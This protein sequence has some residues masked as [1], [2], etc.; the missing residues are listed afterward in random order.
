MGDAR[1]PGLPGKL[2]AMVRHATVSSFSPEQED[3]GAFSNLKSELAS[4]FPLVHERIPHE[5]VGDRGLLYS[6]KGRDP[7]LAPAML[8]AHF[9]VVPAADADLW[10]HGPFSGDI[11]EGCLW[12]RGTQDIKVCMATILEAAENLLARGFEPLRT[13]YFAF[14]GDEETG[15]SRGARRIAALLEERG[16]RASF[17][18]DEGGPVSVGLVSFVAEPL[19]L[20]GV[21]EKGYMDV[22]LEASGKG[23][24]ASMPPRRTAAGD[25]ARAV[26][27]MEAK[28]FPA[29]LARTVRGFLEAL[30]PLTRR[31]YRFLF[32]HLGLSG[33]LVMKAFA[34]SPS[35]DALLRT[36]AAATMLSGSPKENVLAD[37]ATANLNVRL[38]PGHSAA[39]ALARIASIAAPFGV[40][41]RIHH[42]E[43]HA[44]A[45]AESPASG[46]GWEAVV[47]ALGKSHPGVAAVPFL[48]SG[49]TDTKHYP[50]VAAA[51]YRF[52]PIRST[53]EDLARIHARDERIRLEDLDDCALFFLSLME[54]L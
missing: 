21:A 10:R 8:C 2:S 35:T 18:L 54:S 26:A 45:S 49:G 34:K 36:T 47:A 11:A 28:P 40:T 38:M 42:E 15:G 7:S 33:P 46:E 51:S 52:A 13:L 41:A 5:E 25:I 16:V 23:G 30:A 31:P 39:D 37:R 3:E 48:M 1:F 32:S 50:K 6:W 4:L 43:F 27:A 24:H 29:V 19:A 14:G 20:V 12:G 17:L 53:K 9:D 44:E 22:L